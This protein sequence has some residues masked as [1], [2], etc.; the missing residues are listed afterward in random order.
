MFFRVI[1][2]LSIL[3]LAGRLTY[4][5]F[6]KEAVP[7]GAKPCSPSSTGYIAWLGRKIASVFRPAGL[8][9]LQET[10]DY[11]AAS[12]P[13]SVQRWA[14]IG[15]TS[16]LAY[17]AL[18]GFAFA[19]FSSRGLFGLPLLFHVI[20]GG[21]FAVS[22]AVIVVRRAKEYSSFSE[23]AGAARRPL[24]SLL[25]DVPRPL[26]QSL[27]FWIFTLAGLF[28]VATAL[29]SMLPYFTFKA[30]VAFVETHRWSALVIVLSAMLFFDALP[31]P[32][33]T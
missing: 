13:P 1:A 14:F 24:I 2:L 23:L 3:G 7:P 19:L 11:C 16:S 20:A 4:V 31:A 9:S 33:S 18:S 8:K 30:Q 12:Y 29:L 22:L 32:K 10:Y 17:L 21:I 27:L 5:R 15:L 6:R 28:L 26:L 25:H